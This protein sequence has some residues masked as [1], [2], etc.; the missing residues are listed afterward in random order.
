M[1]ERKELN[2]EMLDD[3]NGGLSAGELIEGVKKAAGWY[4]D[5]QRS[6][7]KVSLGFL[8]EAD[9]GD[10][11]ETVGKVLE[12]TDIKGL[13]DVGSIITKNSKPE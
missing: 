4:M 6:A 13:K 12:S 11:I 8:G 3:V 5:K 10:A 7:S 1:S 9:L 2:E